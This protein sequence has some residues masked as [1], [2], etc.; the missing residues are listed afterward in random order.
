[1]THHDSNR[2]GVDPQPRNGYPPVVEMV[3]EIAAAVAVVLTPGILLL[4][5]HVLGW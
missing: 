4:I 3:G 1:M 5:V 2:A